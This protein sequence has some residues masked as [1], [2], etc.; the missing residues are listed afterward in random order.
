MQRNS[1]SRQLL[2]SI[3]YDFVNFV[4]ASPGGF[5]EMQDGMP[6]TLDM[7]IFLPFPLPFGNKKCIATTVCELSQVRQFS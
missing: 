2:S 3:F 6:S 1:L 7:R 4:I 5:G